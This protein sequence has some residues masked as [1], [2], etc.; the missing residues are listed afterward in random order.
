MESVIAQVFPVQADRWIAVVGAPTG[1]FMTET[2]SPADVGPQVRRSLADALGR[3][4]DVRL[5][6]DRGR[7]WT[8]GQAIGQLS[9]MRL[10]GHRRTPWFKRLLTVR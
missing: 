4:P 7:P 5:V 9:R 2:A 6:D 8:P 10:A 3:V 1:P